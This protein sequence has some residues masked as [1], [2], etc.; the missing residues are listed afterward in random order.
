MKFNL[1]NHGY[2]VV[3]TWEQLEALQEELRE[4]GLDNFVRKYKKKL[5]RL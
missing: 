3:N 1:P 5:K 4:L 2:L